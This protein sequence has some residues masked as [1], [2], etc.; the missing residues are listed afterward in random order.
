MYMLCMW[1]L[2]SVLGLPCRSSCFATYVL[3]QNAMG[4]I[5]LIILLILVL[6][7]FETAQ[8]AQY[9]SHPWFQDL[10]WD[11]GGLAESPI[12]NT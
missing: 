8:M 9:L 11:P 12:Q 4:G 6:V 7:L 3:L 10:I 2:D 5:M 1:R